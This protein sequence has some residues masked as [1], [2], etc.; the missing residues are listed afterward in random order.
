MNKKNSK[1]L[2]IRLRESFIAAITNSIGTKMF[3][4]LFATVDGKRKDIL[5]NGD[6]SCAVYVSSMLSIFG[7]IDRPHAKVDSTVKEMMERGWFEIKRPKVGCVLVWGEIDFGD[8]GKHKH[9][10]FYVGGGE[11]ISHDDKTR[12]PA[13]HLYRYKGRSVEKMLWHDKLEA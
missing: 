12:V 8:S 4:N 2:K 1:K 9:I 5:N 13:P 7:L 11:A 6:L 10:G 3:R